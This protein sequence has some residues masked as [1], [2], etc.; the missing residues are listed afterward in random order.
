M[1][2]ILEQGT[3]F[4]FRSETMDVDEIEEW[5]SEQGY[6]EDDYGYINADGTIDYESLRETKREMEEEESLPLAD[7]P[8]GRAYLWFISQGIIYPE[9]IKINIISSPCPGNDWHGVEIK[10]IDSIVKLQQLFLKKGVKVNFYIKN[11]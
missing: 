9:E 7:Y 3:D 11:L 1:N 6:L 5:A 8:S 10:G 4:I 2:F